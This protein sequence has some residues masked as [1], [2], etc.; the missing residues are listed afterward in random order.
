MNEWFR[1]GAGMVWYCMVERAI[2]VEIND[3]PE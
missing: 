3:E 2:D 1:E